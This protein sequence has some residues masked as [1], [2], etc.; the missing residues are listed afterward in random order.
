MLFKCTNQWHFFLQAPIRLLVLL[1]SFLSF[2]VM[3]CLDHKRSPFF[4][5]N[6]ARQWKSKIMQINGKKEER[7]GWREGTRRP[8]RFCCFLNYH[9]ISEMKI[10]DQS[11]TCQSLNNKK[12]QS[13]RSRISTAA[14]TFAARDEQT[15]FIKDCSPVS[16]KMEAKVSK[17]A[18]VWF[19]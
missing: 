3:F 19:N 9:F 14:L 7:L 8:W 4:L 5:Q 1:T 18:C 10:P 13:Q 17:E 6:H 15:L 2:E 11:A 12:S 16:K